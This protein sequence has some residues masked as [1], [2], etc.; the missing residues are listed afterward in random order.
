MALEL[1]SRKQ[2][3]I[4]PQRDKDVSPEGVDTYTYIHATRGVASDYPEI[5]EHICILL[6]YSLSR[7]VARSFNYFSDFRFETC[8][9]KYLVGCSLS[10]CIFYSTS[11]GCVYEIGNFT[12][13]FL[14][15][16]D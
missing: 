2:R 12:N 16:A 4:N 14:Y 6:K 3:H 13:L 1:E 7:L 15:R 9:C 11:R 8:F 5:Y 10:G